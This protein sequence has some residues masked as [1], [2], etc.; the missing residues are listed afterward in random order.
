MFWLFF[1]QNVHMYTNDQ[2]RLGGG[3]V[4]FWHRLFFRFG[5]DHCRRSFLQTRL[6]LD[7][8]TMPE[9][10]LPTENELVPD[11]KEL[12]IEPEE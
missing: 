3:N 11:R 9:N 8:A 6:W 12:V 1:L 4:R 2:F 10:I 7:L 5:S